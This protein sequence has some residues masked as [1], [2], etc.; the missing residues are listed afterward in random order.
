FGRYALWRSTVTSSASGIAGVLEPPS[1]R[2]KVGLAPKVSKLSKSA[3]VQ[4]ISILFMLISR[5]NTLHG[6]ALQRLSRCLTH[7]VKR[8]ER[9]RG[10]RIGSTWMTDAVDRNNYP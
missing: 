5:H 1:A 10:L 9:N 8:F 4:R 7:F 2:S 6:Q 3:V